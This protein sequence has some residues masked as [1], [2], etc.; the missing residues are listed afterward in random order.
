MIIDKKAF[1]KELHQ[2]PELSGREEN[3]AKKIREFYR[4][5]SKGL[6]NFRTWI[7]RAGGNL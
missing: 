4:R 3:T 7:D 6:H 2:Y 5:S 1:R